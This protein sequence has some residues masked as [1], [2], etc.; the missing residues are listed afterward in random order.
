MAKPFYKLSDADLLSWGTALS[1]RA[2]ATA[3]AFHLTDVQVDE[4]T[5]LVGT[6]STALAAWRDNTTRTPVASERK[7]T[8]RRALIDGAKYLVNTV[9]SNPL[10]SDEQ[11]RELGITPRKRPTPVEPP[12]TPPALENIGTSGRLA[13]FT[14]RSPNRP[15]G[16]KSRGVGGVSV[17]T[18]LGDAAPVD[19]AQ[20][21][22]EMLVTKPTFALDFSTRTASDTVWVTCFWYTD[23]GD[24]SVSS[25]PVCV[26]LPAATALPREV[27][28]MKIA[29]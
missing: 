14:V 11:R 8:A 27:P 6:F 28:S 22:F 7:Q 19:P 1:T 18:F 13:A 20:W 26:K 12:A 4:F 25:P 9:N 2:S 24:A 23:K 21:Q 5:D 17:F 15:R 3:A 16:G 29:A 10:T